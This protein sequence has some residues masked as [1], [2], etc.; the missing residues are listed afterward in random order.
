M[1]LVIMEPLA[2][3]KVVRKN[4]EVTVRAIIEQVAKYYNL[5]KG[6]IF[7]RYKPRIVAEKKHMIFWLIYK[8]TSMKLEHIAHLLG[9]EHSVIS[10]GSKNFERLLEIDNDYQ[11][12]VREI[13]AYLL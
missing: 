6:E 11:T 8:H 12:A 10:K 7:H 2:R 5:T 3:V 9:I 1:E 13:E 4:E